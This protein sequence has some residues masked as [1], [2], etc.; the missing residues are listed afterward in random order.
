MYYI[1]LQLYCFFR[2]PQLDLAIL[3][4]V[5][6]PVFL[7]DYRILTF[8]IP[9][10]RCAFDGYILRIIILPLFFLFDFSMKVSSRQI[11]LYNSL[12]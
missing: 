1:I 7:S 3:L 6:R 2:N 8:F 10:E 9:E 11:L 12:E 4:E 5:H